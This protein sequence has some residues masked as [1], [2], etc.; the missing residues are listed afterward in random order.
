VRRRTGL[1]VDLSAPDVEIG[2]EVDDHE[3]FVYTERLA[4]Q[5]GLPIGVSGQALVLLSGGFDS[6]VAG[7][8]AMRRGLRCDYVHFTGL[9]FTTRESVY[10]AYA[11]VRHLSRFQPGA[12]LFIVPLGKAQRSIATG[13]AGRLGVVSQ[14]RVMVMTAT[15]LA[16][17]HGAEALVT[18]DAL[19]Q[20][21][22][23][24]LQNL[25]VVESATDLPLLR[26]LLGFDKAEITAEAARIGTKAISEL[27]DEDCCTMLASGVAETRAKLADLERLE[28]RLDVASLADGL[29]AQCSVVTPGTGQP[30]AQADLLGV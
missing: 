14:R 30:P 15:R 8:R 24:T 2:V 3:I 18:G 17:I 28:R 11:L 16:R 9:P 22:S 25:S 1:G 13:G 27:P 6:P 29:A 10:K 19:G 26:P 7:Y 23:Q 21:A 5:G 12:R 20:V 4:G